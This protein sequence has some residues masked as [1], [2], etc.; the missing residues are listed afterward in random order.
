MMDEKAFRISDK[1][2][3]QRKFIMNKC[4]VILSSS[5]MR[6]KAQCPKSKVLKSV[7]I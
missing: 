3:L 2:A 4:G 1:T 5:G 7:G 6:S